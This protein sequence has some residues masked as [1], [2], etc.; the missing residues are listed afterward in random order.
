MKPTRLDVPLGPER[1]R[2][3]YDRF[4]HAQAFAQVDPWAERAEGRHAGE[5]APIATQKL[6]AAE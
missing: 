6:M 1:R 3:L 5:F 4:V 2:A